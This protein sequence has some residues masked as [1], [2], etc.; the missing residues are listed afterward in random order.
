MAKTQ[1]K[2]RMDFNIG[3]GLSL[4]EQIYPKKC[5]TTVFGILFLSPSG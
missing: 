5:S 3:L 2:E 4:Q 1:K